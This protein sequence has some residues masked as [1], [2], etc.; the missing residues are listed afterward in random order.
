MTEANEG[1]ASNAT[2]QETAVAM[3]DEVHVVDVRW[4]RRK[5]DGSYV[6]SETAID[7]RGPARSP[8]KRFSIAVSPV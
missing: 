7:G 6:T 2:Q 5:S 8:E 1:D 4:D 3:G